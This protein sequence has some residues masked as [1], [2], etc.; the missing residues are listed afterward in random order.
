MG[1]FSGVGVV[2]QQQQKLFS[3]SFDQSE[4]F[5]NTTAVSVIGET[6]SDDYTTLI[7]LTME[8]APLRG[9]D[10]DRDRDCGFIIKTDLNS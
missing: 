7:K 1:G 6:G 8:S 3:S 9:C 10:C 2:M 4:C 5:N